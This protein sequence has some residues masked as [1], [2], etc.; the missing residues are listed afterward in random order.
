MHFYPL[1]YQY[2]LNTWNSSNAKIIWGRLQTNVDYVMP[3]R[4]FVVAKGISYRSIATSL[5]NMPLLS[6]KC[7]FI[8]EEQISR[9]P[10]TSISKVC[11]ISSNALTDGFTGMMCNHGNTWSIVGITH[12]HPGIFNVTKSSIIVKQFHLFKYACLRYSP[13]M[14]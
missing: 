7:S 5:V 12:F 14:V 8:C 3:C 4:A 10:I 9:V 13:N 1:I 6:L 11:I 2:V